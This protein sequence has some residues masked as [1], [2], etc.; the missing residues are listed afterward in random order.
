MVSIMFNKRNNLLYM[1]QGETKLVEAV[2]SDDT[3]DGVIVRFLEK[4]DDKYVYSVTVKKDYL[5]GGSKDVKF[6]LD[7]N[8]I[9]F[10]TKVEGIVFFGNARIIRKDEEDNSTLPEH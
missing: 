2:G 8:N 7:E 4:K 3:Q 6:I 5:E 1:K 9:L 10:E